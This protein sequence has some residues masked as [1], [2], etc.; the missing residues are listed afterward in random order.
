MTHESTIDL[1]VRFRQQMKELG[2]DSPA[3]HF[4]LA[5][6][7][8][9]D[10]VVLAHLC[11]ASGYPFTIAHCNFRLR[12]AESDG[13]EEFV[14]GLARR[15]DVPFISNRFDTKSYAATHRMG[16]QEA[17]RVLRY[18]WFDKLLSGAEGPASFS[19]LLTAHHA[20][21]NIETLLMNFFKGTGIKG[22]QG[23]RSRS[24]RILRPLLFAFREEIVTYAGQ[25][26]L[27]FR[28]DSSNLSNV[29]T[30]NYFRNEL[31]PA[32]EKVFPQVRQNL[33][34][35]IRRFTDIGHIYGEWIEKEKKKILIPRGPEYH[36][37]IG[38]LGRSHA[39]PTLLYEIM[40]DF[41]FGPGQ[42]EEVMALM[43]AGSGKQ[44]LSSTHRVLNNRGWLIIAPAGTT[45]AKHFLLGPD[46]H[47]L[48]FGDH[49]LTVEQVSSP[50]SISS[51]KN[52]AQLDARHI[53]YPLLLRQWKA[54]DYF[55]P[56]GMKKKKKLSRFLIDQ[57]V[58]LIE[59]ED[60]WVLESDGKILW[61][62]GHRIDERFRISERTGAMLRITYQ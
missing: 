53:R 47:I 55:Y 61:V 23:I 17:A 7:G 1:L 25:N 29:Y 21:D 62:V 37:S 5:V 19:M 9:M 3:G 4:L 26:N 24:G 10:S 28:E 27:A 31:I 38:R 58:S 15:L 22:L 41:G 40:S 50:G 13:D 54:G 46:D 30:R 12:D 11:K 8:G 59:K 57:K 2:F 44:V 56:L 36:I 35:N 18:E 42:V 16:I 20:D 34:N 45:A 32:V 52:V 51:D 33:H 39:L 6:S 43:K 49:T 60:I 48:T 14:S